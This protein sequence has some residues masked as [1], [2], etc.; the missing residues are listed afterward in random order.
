MADNAR[1]RIFNL[2][3]AEEAGVATLNA[4]E[5]SATNSL[6]PS[7]ARGNLTWGLNAF[8]TER[9]V[10]I[11]TTSVDCFCREHAIP[12]IDILKLDIQGGEFAALT[13][14]QGMLSRQKIGVI[15]LEII[16]AQTYEGQHKLHE[17]LS[18]LDSFGFELLDLYEP[19]RRGLELLQADF[20]FL[21][22][23][24]KQ[25]FEDVSV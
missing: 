25:T 7:A 16:L 5:S 24:L 19:W 8:G 9:Q 12:V 2:A 10:K 1:T 11:N 3:V 6:L 22:R 20:L 18:L 17:Y 14:A 23:G 4:N 21:R 13:G 15:Y